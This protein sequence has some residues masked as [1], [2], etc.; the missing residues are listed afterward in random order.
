MNENERESI[1]R[2]DINEE[3]TTEENGDGNGNRN[4]NREVLAE[5]PMGYKPVR[6]L[7][8]NFRSP[9]QRKCADG[10]FPGIPYT[11][12]Y[13]GFCHRNSSR[14]ERSSVQIPGGKGAGQGKPGSSQRNLPCF[15]NICNFPGVQLFCRNLYQKPDI[16]SSDY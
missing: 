16:R 11:E 5:N 2:T 8:L 14:Y 9:S 6:G 13:S 12:P 3:I 7:L 10:R 15:C 1:E 4:G